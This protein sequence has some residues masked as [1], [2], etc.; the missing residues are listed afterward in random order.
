MPGK[1]GLLAVCRLGDHKQTHQ[2]FPS[3][4]WD[5]GDRDLLGRQ[6]PGRQGNDCLD[7][8]KHRMRDT[9]SHPDLGT[10]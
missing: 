9:A 3:L 1:E 5:R 4:Q 7:D 10:G 6:G 2:S 8:A